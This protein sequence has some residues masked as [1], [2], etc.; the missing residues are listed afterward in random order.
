MQAEYKK[1]REENEREF[2][3]LKKELNLNED[4]DAKPEKYVNP[5]HAKELGIKKVSM[6]GDDVEAHIF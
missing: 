5:L 6:F 2:E 1:M 4:L 3:K